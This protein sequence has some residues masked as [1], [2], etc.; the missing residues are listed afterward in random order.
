MLTIHPKPLAQTLKPICAAIRKESTPSTRWRNPWLGAIRVQLTERETRAAPMFE[1][2]EDMGPFP[3]ERATIDVLLDL[4]NAY[5]LATLPDPKKPLTIT[6][7][8]ATIESD[9]APLMRVD[10]RT[11]PCLVVSQ[12][13]SVPGRTDTMRF[14]TIPV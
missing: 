12:P 11:G 2:V 8:T 7:E 10:T 4:D 6:V 1:S 5:A 13:S 14:T 3:N 9:R